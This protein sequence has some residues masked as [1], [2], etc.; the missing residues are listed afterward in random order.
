MHVHFDDG[1]LRRSDAVRHLVDPHEANQPVPGV[2]PATWPFGEDRRPLYEVLECRQHRINRIGRTA[3]TTTR[4]RSA[5]R[6]RS[7]RRFEVTLPTS[8]AT[9]L[10]ENLGYYG[11]RLLHLRR[12]RLL[13]EC[14]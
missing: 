3:W 1:R 4:C 11:W 13:A 5:A 9:A 14:V 10:T 7:I 2:G 6:G 8:G 12:R